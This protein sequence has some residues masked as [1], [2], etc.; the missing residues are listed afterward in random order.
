MR[1]FATFARRVADEPVFV[2][3]GVQGSGTNLLSRILERGF[4]FSLI[5]DGSVVFKS[6]AGL[7]IDP[8]PAKVRRAF[9]LIRSRL[10]PSP[11]VRKTCRL[12]KANADYDGIDRHVDPAEIRSGADLARFVYAYGAFRLGTSRMA[13]KSDDIWEDIEHIDSVLPKR[14]IILLTRD[15]RDNLLSVSNKDFGPIE[16]LNAAWYVKRRFATYEAE[17]QR[18]PCAH[19]FHVRYEDLLESPLSV[20]HDLSQHFD[21]PPVAGGERAVEALQIRRG[22]LRKWSALGKRTLAHV[23]AVLRDELT[24][25]G[26]ASSA[27]PSGPPGTAVWAITTASDTTKRLGQKGKRLVKRLGR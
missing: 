18:T 3:L 17:Y 5:E 16:P 24:T 1:S 4:N 26:Y 13:I 22:N 11:L 14:R 19:R 2:V 6:A 12:I 20:V 9:A 8:T 7:G 27:E 10:A 23:E 21:L 15:F 25:Y